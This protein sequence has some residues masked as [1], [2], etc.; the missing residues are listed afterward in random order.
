MKCPGS[1]SLVDDPKG[2]FGKNKHGN[3]K[4]DGDKDGDSKIG[5]DTADD[6]NKKKTDDN[7]ESSITK[8]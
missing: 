6:D 4:N 5:N 7:K 8:P 3:T 2:E 1:S